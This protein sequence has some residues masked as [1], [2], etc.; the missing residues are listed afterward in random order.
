[1][2]TENEN[3]THPGAKSQLAIVLEK[4]IVWIVLLVT[5]ISYLGTL[6]F[7]FVSEDS[8]TILFNPFIR[9]WKFVPTYFRTPGWASLAPGSVGNYYRPIF[10]VFMRVNYAIFTNRPLGWHM[11]AIALHLVVTWLVFAVNRKLT[12]DFTVAW[13]AALIFGAHPV[14]H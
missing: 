7:E 10:Q 11:A 1:M 3:P 5:A 2:H 9:A 8:S 12:G 13:L 14:H 6:Q 4:K